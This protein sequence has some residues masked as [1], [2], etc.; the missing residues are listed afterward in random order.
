[1]NRITIHRLSEHDEQL[2]WQGQINDVGSL[3]VFGEQ[4]TSPHVQQTAYKQCD[5]RETTPG[6]K[7]VTHHG[8]L[9][10]L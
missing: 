2:I 5:P 1:M 3:C 7:G 6:P 4:N 10:H 9:F 8:S